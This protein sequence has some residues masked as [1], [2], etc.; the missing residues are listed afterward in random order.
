MDN[1][2]KTRFSLK[3]LTSAMLSALTLTISGC[4]KE[5]NQDKVSSTMEQTTDAIQSNAA[6]AYDSAKQTAEGIGEKSSEMIGAAGDKLAEAG[7]STMDATKD[8]AG[9][10]ADKAQQAK[11]SASEGLAN[12]GESA[13][14]AAQSAQETVADAAS[15]TADKAAAGLS[16]LKESAQSAAGAATETVADTAGAVTDKAKSVAG[17]VSETAGQAADSAKA[18]AAAGMAGMGAAAQSAASTT[19]EAS[20]N[21][22]ETSKSAA[23]KA[24]E[25]VE[26]AKDMAAA[27]LSGT[28]DAAQAALQKMAGVETFE[29]ALPDGRKIEIPTGTTLE[30]FAKNLQSG[31]FPEGENLLADR[32]T[33]PTG[34]AQLSQEA[35]A[36]LDALA[37]ILKSH[38]ELKV[39][40]KGYT[41]NTGDE[42]INQ[43]LAEA[44]AKAVKEALIARG[45]SPERI[46]TEGLSTAEPVASNATAEGRSQNR[47]VDILVSR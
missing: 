24:A 34:S 7:E 1:L 3:V 14:S 40:V 38:P 18:A 26:Q 12:L 41:D 19:S 42:A 46:I 15:N 30:S 39:T 37:E 33:F 35:Q 29:Y 25:T 4:S 28:G 36:R 43:K 23:R 45:I 32:T 13:Q 27:E 17:N 6:D 31:A 2:K 21:L 44:R 8:I 9:S 10:I 16:N 47:R 22:A 5:E 20:A 11:E